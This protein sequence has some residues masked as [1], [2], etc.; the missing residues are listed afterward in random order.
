MFYV[1]VAF[2]RNQKL[3]IFSILIFTHAIFKGISY[4]NN[5]NLKKKN[6]ISHHI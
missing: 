6:V 1:R 3:P 2:Y 4:V 5:Y